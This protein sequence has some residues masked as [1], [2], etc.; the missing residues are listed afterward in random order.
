MVDDIG[1]AAADRVVKVH[2]SVGNRSRDTFI[3]PRTTHQVV[4]FVVEGR[5]YVVTIFV[6]FNAAPVV[7]RCFSHH[8]QVIKA[9]NRHVMERAFSFYI[10]GDSS[11][12]NDCPY[13]DSAIDFCDRVI[14]I[15][16]VVFRLAT[17][18][19]AQNVSTT[20]IE[21][22]ID[23]ISVPPSRTSILDHG[24]LAI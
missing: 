20:A 11:F 13:A 17:A 22:R 6:G 10:T 5:E 15:V 3:F 7:V 9:A 19:A 1:L 24:R 23:F 4:V 12:F 16:R 8:A 18:G 2:I 21:A 14:D